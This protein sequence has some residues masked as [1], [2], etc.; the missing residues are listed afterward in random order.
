MLPDPVQADELFASHSFP[1]KSLHNALVI[2]SGR[3]QLL[4]LNVKCDAE[5]AHSLPQG[6]HPRVGGQLPPNIKVIV[7][8]A[9]SYSQFQLKILQRCSQVRPNGSVCTIVLQEGVK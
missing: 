6:L 1:D 4:V 8:W 2:L 7:E 5:L 3:G 9:A